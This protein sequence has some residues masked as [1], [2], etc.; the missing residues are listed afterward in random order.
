LKTKNVIAAAALLLLSLP[1]FAQKILVSSVN[2]GDGNVV[3]ESSGTG[4]PSPL[5]CSGLARYT[6][7][8]DTTG[9]PVWWCKA[10]TMI[11]LPVGGSGGGVTLPANGV[12]FQPSSGAT[13]VAN[14]ADILASGTG[15]HNLSTTT[16][17]TTIVSAL[18]TEGTAGAT[19]IG[20]HPS[21]SL[22]GGVWAGSSSATYKSGGGFTLAGSSSANA[23]L[24]NAGVYNYS[25]SISNANTASSGTV[26]YLRG[27]PSNLSDGLFLAISGNSVVI[28]DCTPTCTTLGTGTTTATTGTITGTLTGGNVSVTVYGVTVTGTMLASSPN[29]TSTYFGFSNSTVGQ[30]LSFSTLTVTGSWAVTTDVPCAHGIV[31]GSGLCVTLTANQGTAADSAGNIVSLPEKGYTTTTGNTP[32]TTVAWSEDL[33]N[34]IFDPRNPSHA[35]GVN[36]STPAAAWQATFDAAACYAAETGATPSIFMPPGIWSVGTQASPSLTGGPG[37]AYLGAPGNQYGGTMFNATYLG[38]PVVT[39]A[40]PYTVPLCPDGTTNVTDS[41]GGGYVNNIHVHGCGEGGCVNPTGHATSPG[42]GLAQQGIYIVLG[43]GYIGN[44]YADHN[45]GPGMEIDGLDSHEVGTIFSYNNNEYLLFGQATTGDVYNPSTDGVH[46]NV[47]L[48]CGDCTFS[49]IEDYGFLNNPGAELDHLAG[50]VWYGGNSSVDGIFLQLEEIGIYRSEGVGFARLHNFRLDGTW[51]A[52]IYNGDNPIEY[53]IGEIDGYCLSS[54]AVTTLGYCDGIVSIGGGPGTAYSQIG[55]TPSSIFG[56][57]YK[58]GDIKAQDLSTI[59]KSVTVDGEG[60]PVFDDTFAAVGVNPPGQGSSYD[61]PDIPGYNGPNTVTG[62]APNVAGLK[63]VMMSNTSPTNIVRLANYKMG[64]DYYISLNSAN[65]VLVSSLNGGEFI[66]CSGYNVTGPAHGMHFVPTNNVTYQ[67]GYTEQCPTIPNNYWLTNWSNQTPPATDTISADDTFGSKAVHALAPL[68]NG[69]LSVA[70]GSVSGYTSCY[71]AQV[72][73]AGGKQT[74]APICAST[75]VPPVTT[76]MASMQYILSLPPDWTR[77][78]VYRESSTNSGLPAGTI[79]DVTSSTGLPQ[80][81]QGVTI[82]DTFVPPLNTTVLGSARQSINMTGTYNFDATN[83]PGSSTSLCVPG[84]VKVNPSTTVGAIYYCPTED[85]WVEAPL[86]FTSTFGTTSCP[87]SGGGIGT[88]T[89]SGSPTVNVFSIFTAAGV[90]GNSHLDDGKTT[91]STITSSENFSAPNIFTNSISGLST[92]VNGQ[93]TWIYRGTAPATPGANGYQYSPTQ[94][95]VPTGGIST[96]FDPNPTTGLRFDTVTTVSGTAFL[97]ESHRSVVGSGGYIPGTAL[98]TLPTPGD[99]VLWGPTGLTDGGAPPTSA[100]L[101]SSNASNQIVPYA[102]G[103]QPS[104]NTTF[105][106]SALATVSTTFISTGIVMPPAPPGAEMHGQCNLNIESNNTAGFVQFALNNSATP[107]NMWVNGYSWTGSAADEYSAISAS[108][109]TAVTASLSFV[110]ANVG[111]KV[112]I[113]FTI[114]NGS[115]AD[116]ITPYFKSNS[117]SYTMTIEPGSSCGWLL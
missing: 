13:R 50:I 70:P 14:P 117:A 22:P 95:A 3:V 116:V 49:N 108:G 45:N 6:Q 94:A 102:P 35:G 100:G 19:V 10:G 24:I 29:F 17:F 8:D 51:W 15:W 38:H 36:G 99:F 30:T 107:S 69:T 60:A 54:T 62:T 73:V 21:I 85:H 37:V 82:N 112:Q 44:L 63:H 1:A 61:P 76:S 59:D 53:S 104:V 65:D 28:E 5:S 16:S 93:W 23:A 106:N 79:A 109:T 80:V 58:T 2:Y 11:H 55:M 98:S 96:S 90:I 57:S 110:T 7:E 115:T 92:T 47:E 81:A 78:I 12:P 27:S 40:S 48:N 89:T 56:I 26:F 113:D 4:A 39:I 75:A 41:Q 86:C 52:G 114:E 18:G 91:A 31:E 42:D 66:T 103:V 111:Y 72:Y 71:D 20:T 77:Y 32:T 43:Q 67:D 64:V 9:N 101:L 87:G 33:N 88:V 83:I 84:Q 34:G 74:N 25:F 68:A 105:L 97:Q 46:G